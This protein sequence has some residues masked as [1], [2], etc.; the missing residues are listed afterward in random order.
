[1]RAQSA[2]SGDGLSSTTRYTFAVPATY[3]STFLK[4]STEIFLNKSF[5]I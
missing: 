5:G 4:C 1:M 2:S 3:N